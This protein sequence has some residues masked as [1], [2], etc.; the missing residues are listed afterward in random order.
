MGEV[1]RAKDLRLARTVAIK[2]LPG[3]LAGSADFRARLHREARAAAQLA[4]PHICTLHDLGEDGD[5]SYLVMELLEGVT[6]A[7]RLAK[8]PLPLEEGLTVATQIAAALEA[9]HRA[10]IVHRDLKPG[11]IMLTRSGVKLLDFGLATAPDSVLK[12]TP[13]GPTATT[14]LT[15]AGTILG[16][17]HYMAPEQLEARPA[18]HRTDIWA[19]GAVLY[20]I[21]TGRPAFHADSSAG[22]VGAILKDRPLPV[23][24]QR[25]GVSPLIDRVVADCLHKDPDERWQN[26]GDVR[27]QLAWASEWSPLQANG[28]G[29][30]TST[31][32][33]ALPWSI[34]VAA[35]LVAGYLVRQ[36]RTSAARDVVAPITRPVVFDV[37]PP[38][39]TRWGRQSAQFS[40][41]PEGHAVAYLA[42]D[43][44]GRQH[45]FVRDFGT[46]DTRDTPISNA[47]LSV[48]W[49]DERHVMVLGDPVI[50]QVDVMT[51]VV[52]PV[53]QNPCTLLPAGAQ[54]T[55]DAA[56][57]VVFSCGPTYGLFLIGP[58]DVAARRLTN[59]DAQRAD[60]SHASPSLLPQG[61][62]ILY[63]RRSLAGELDGVASR[64][65]HT[66]IQEAPAQAVFSAGHLVFPTGDTL[67]AQ[68]F[69]LSTLALRGEPVPL[70][71]PVFRGGG[72]R[73]MFSAAPM[74]TL[75]VLAGAIST[76]TQ[77]TWLDRTG[78]VI[79]AV[80]PPGQWGAFDITPD[81]STIAANGLGAS[82][83]YVFDR[84]DGD[85]SD[86]D[87]NIRDDG[88]VLFVRRGGERGLYRV[89]LQ[90][91]Q[92]Q[93]LKASDSGLY[94][95][96]DAMEDGRTILFR[97]GV[98]TPDGF[99]GN[100][101]EENSQ[102][103]VR[104][105]ARVD[106]VHISNDG[107]WIAYNAPAETGQDEVYIVS[108]RSG[109]RWQVSTA[110]GMQPVW[111]RDGRELYYLGS[112]ATLYAVAVDV[113][114]DTITAG[115]PQAL[116]KTALRDLTANIEQYRATADGKRFVF[117]V[118]V[119]D[120]VQPPIRVYL[121]WPASLTQ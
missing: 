87:P 17:L 39:G 35:M 120:D 77:F 71:I 119:G 91:G 102:V 118:P 59:P 63:T 55:G 7:D 21:L 24:A 104:G 16:T 90:G 67:T 3:N 86:V 111:R 10:G 48:G 49:V 105:R 38:L 66:V 94:S 116:F 18:D 107:A 100:P 114:G 69:D 112:D 46:P 72:N 88:S 106:Q 78:A 14:R 101:E 117:R 32:G 113:M 6:L 31:L 15:A 22:L 74:G 11:N 110:G 5:T 54:V 99:I 51:G 53:G 40:V 70:R 20:E 19:F 58:R 93:R 33:R 89:T 1:Y 80:G 36:G 57:G 44:S 23:S 95:L 2:V 43:R 50:E 121:N 85:Q 83:L 96:D 108:R 84:P 79:R 97:K 26:I 52:R 28:S 25:P 115:A 60:E 76:T 81:G 61:A 29:R 34:A 109:A 9:A 68:P 27:R 41:S 56:V 12:L 13:E 82:S 42:S 4:H 75:A 98:A 47:G 73:A 8:G 92:E 103:L 45:L 62:G 37:V 65:D 30:G 64:L